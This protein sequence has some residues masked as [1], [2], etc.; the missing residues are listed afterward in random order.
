MARRL[1]QSEVPH[2]GMYGK[3]RVPKKQCDDPVALA[4]LVLRVSGLLRTQLRSIAGSID[5]PANWP[6][7][8]RARGHIVEVAAAPLG[9]RDRRLLT[10]A[11]HL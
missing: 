8:V 11:S 5:A 6:C 9:L 7:A 10:R 3:R 2:P 1:T 4:E